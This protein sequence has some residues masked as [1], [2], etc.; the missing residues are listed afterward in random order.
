LNDLEFTKAAK[1]EAQ[2]SIIWLDKTGSKIRVLL[3]DQ[4]VPGSNSMPT[5][6]ATA[7]EI[8][9]GQFFGNIDEY[10]AALAAA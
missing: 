1:A 10:K 4:M 6:D 7:E 5:R 2:K 9:A 3:P 8:E